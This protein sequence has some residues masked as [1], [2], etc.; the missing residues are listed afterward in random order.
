MATNMLLTVPL[1]LLLARHAAAGGA[2]RDDA[3]LL[4]TIRAAVRSYGSSLQTIELDY[5]FTFVRPDRTSVSERYWAMKGNRVLY[6]EK[7]ASETGD[8]AF[9][10]FDGKSTLRVFTSG[11]S[12][13]AAIYGDGSKF[14]M[15]AAEQPLA[16]AGLYWRSTVPTPLWE[17]ICGD[18][19]TGPEIVK[20]SAGELVRITLPTLTEDRYHYY[21][22]PRKGYLPKRIVTWLESESRAFTEWNITDFAEVEDPL[23]QKKRWFPTKAVARLEDGNGTKVCEVTS[24]RI[25]HDIADS[26]FEYAVPDGFEVVNELTNVRY[27]KGGLDS[28]ERGVRTATETIPDAETLKGGVIDARPRHSIITW[29]AIALGT[30]GVGGLLVATVRRLRV[31]H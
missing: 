20:D 6:K 24:V 9:S 5:R 14:T 26:L 17:I 29:I 28:L 12:R 11:S 18:S 10:I 4:E 21:L 13:G 15:F 27:I 1:T 3:E 8:R 30:V 31:R 2:N 22:D 16:F 7:G 19:I 23:L 25:N